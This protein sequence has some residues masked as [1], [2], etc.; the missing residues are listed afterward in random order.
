[1]G[2][3]RVGVAGGVGRTAPSVE[4]ARAPAPAPAPPSATAAALA[5]C[6]LSCI[7]LCHLQLD[8]DWLHILRNYLIHFSLSLSFF[9]LLIF[10]TNIYI[11]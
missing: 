3:G 6:L 1:M 7:H 9:Y 2:A 5:T 11:Y 4:R 10:I 8:S